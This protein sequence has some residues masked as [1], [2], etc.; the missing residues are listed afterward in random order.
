[1]ATSGEEK[2]EYM[3][4]PLVIW[5]RSCL[6]NPSV[7]VDYDDLID[8]VLIY[9][10]LLQIDPE[11]THTGV[12]PSHGNS[13]I[14][15][16]NMDIILKNIRYLYKEELGQIIVM[17]PNVVRLGM[18]PNTP[19]GRQD[20]TLLLLLLLS[21]AVQCPNKEIFIEKIKQL[22]I[23]VQH[24]IVDCIK[25]ITDTPLMVLGC[26]MQEPVSPDVMM[27]HIR[28]L[29]KERDEFLHN[30]ANAAITETQTSNSD[31]KKRQNFNV[32][33]ES[34]HLAVELAD[35][36]SKL[37]KQ[38]QELE[39][40]TEALTECREEL[41]HQK[42]LVL[43]LK[44]EVADVVQ[45]ARSA[46]VYRDELDAMREKAEKAEKL[47]AEVQRY[48]DKLSDIEFY[49]TRV[50]ELREDNRVLL[51]TREMLEDQL[52]R[53]RRRGDHMLELEAEILKLN[54]RINELTLERDAKDKKL[55]D[56]YAENAELQV[57]ARSAAHDES[58]TKS[59]SDLDEP[60]GSGDASLS[61]QL[62]NNA[63]AR[64]LRLEL[65][66]RKLLSTIDSL[67]EASFHES[68][69]KI[70]ELDREN[71]ELRINV[72]QLQE[73]CE[74]LTSEN[75]E[76]ELI[77]K[78]CLQENRKLQES[79]E[80]LRMTTDRQQQ[81]LQDGRM[82][83]EELKNEIDEHVK[84]GEEMTNRIK[85]LEA[86][87]NDIEEWK[88]QSGLVPSLRQE[89]S[90]MKSDLLN[91]EKELQNSQK[92]VVKYKETIEEKDV[93]LDDFMSKTESYHKEREK[94]LQEIEDARMQILKL[95]EVERERDE[96]VSKAA[97][98]EE[99]LSVLKAEL[100]SEKVHAQQ[101]KNGLEKLGLKPELFLDPDTAITNLLTIPEF[102]ELLVKELYGSCPRCNSDK[103]GPV[104]DK[105]SLLMQ[106][107]EL[108]NEISALQNAQ[109]QVVVATLQS[110]ITSLTA[111]HTALQLANSQLVAEKDEMAKERSALQGSYDQLLKDQVALQ[112]LHEQ[113]S[114]DH[115]VLLREKETLRQIQKESTKEIKALRELLAKQEACN[116]VV[117]Q[118]RDA[119]KMDS[120]SL[121]NLRAEHSKLKDDFRNL[122]T[123]NEKLKNEYRTIQEE[124]KTLRTEVGSLRLRHTEL[125]GEA[126][127]LSDH[128][129]H[130][131]VQLSKVLNQNEMLL[132]MNSNL[133]ED[134][135]SLME[136]VTRLL[137]QYHELLTHS[138]EDKQH[139]HTEEKLFADK[140][141][142][143]NRQKEKL[144]EKIMDHYK[145]L[146][147]C[148]NKKKGFGASLVRRVRKAGTDLIN[149]SRKS[150]HEDSQ[151]SSMI[152]HGSESGGNESDASIEDDGNSQPML[153]PNILNQQGAGTRQTVY[154]NNEPKM[155]ETAAAATEEPQSQINPTYLVYNR[156]NT[157][158][159]GD[160]LGS[161]PAP[162]SPNQSNRSTKSQTVSPMVSP[163]EEV[164]RKGKK[165][166]SVW[167]EYGC[168]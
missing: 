152:L 25:Q 37:R 85:E 119:L 34:H 86:S 26:E 7:L 163:S 149:K 105:D 129:T 134:R 67:K 154:C 41:E 59:D 144:E 151:H 130:L 53:A 8:G 12:I 83:I 102:K 77:V 128:V 48:K 4:G 65:E 120:T 80:G 143:L 76:L 139:Y 42:D 135:R 45:E 61:E 14:R 60:L 103:Q 99:T 1:M 78:D 18:Q 82:Q 43:K 3:D 47:E 164:K 19:A 64:A 30:W 137:A 91:L 32:S 23:D 167:F 101:L 162:P 63:T 131:E 35:W 20:M 51:E 11:P 95:N 111:Q 168:V 104:L 84:R 115:E 107:G 24:S 68:S 40:K 9:Q 75:K 79:K 52:Q 31:P 87:N 127:T 38:R 141:N 116:S 117:K 145:K 16:K 50:Q 113:L 157:V 106:G 96:L 121:T 109:L 57:L 148:S 21:C 27:D 66:N 56:L 17:A 89:L 110:E 46:K 133:E 54:Q 94:I 92:D 126:A 158:L 55:E 156:V 39:E 161:R 155:T 62:T 114:S 33:S 93:K 100:V 140:L 146:E 73:T 10:V 49:K 118:E 70:L 29:V 88:L 81:E 71:K 69:N 159:G 13:Q 166:N 153:F 132:Q 98:T 125:Q 97:I 123:T 28:N 124:Y 122:F 44:Q 15:I 6:E 2:D 112:S 147:S 74:R 36:K 165:Q 90:S 142:H 5:L 136:H 108:R 22:N 58:F 160:V 138:L 150:W 72:E